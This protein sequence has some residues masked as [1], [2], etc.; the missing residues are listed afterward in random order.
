MEGVGPPG[1]GARGY[2]GKEEDTSMTATML[3]HVSTPKPSVFRS[4]SG[5]EEKWGWEADGDPQ[6]SPG[7][8][9]RPLGQERSH[10]WRPAGQ[11]ISWG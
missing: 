1:W 10:G 2:R 8:G 6:D 9:G 7:G 4:G 11:S 3:R 5:G